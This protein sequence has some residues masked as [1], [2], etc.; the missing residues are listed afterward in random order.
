[1][2]GSDKSRAW[3]KQAGNAFEGETLKAKKMALRAHGCRIAA[4]LDVIASTAST[5]AVTVVSSR[6]SDCTPDVI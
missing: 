3:G 6:D 2:G 5:V 1:M 4:D